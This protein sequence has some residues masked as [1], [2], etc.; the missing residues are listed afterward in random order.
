MVPLFGFGRR[1]VTSLWNLSQRAVPSVR[2]PDHTRKASTQ[3]AEA[4][5][6][7]AV[8]QARPPAAAACSFRRCH[9]GGE[10]ASARLWPWVARMALGSAWRWPFLERWL[11][12]ALSVLLARWLTLFSSRPRGALCLLQCCC[13][14]GCRASRRPQR[15]AGGEEAQRLQ[16]GLG[17]LLQGGGRG[18][19]QDQGPQLG[20]VAGAAVHPRL[21][22]HGHLDS[23]PQGSHQPAAAHGACIEVPCAGQ[24]AEERRACM[25]SQAGFSRSLSLSFADYC[26]PV[27]GI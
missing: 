19:G 26:C 7:A 15:A 18:R 27:R 3:G 13:G 8:E 14:V 6:G 5:D 4:P 10:T 20:G 22:Q 11:L 21:R 9:S 23:R 25:S 24:A 12:Q 1:L 17:T 2:G 16:E